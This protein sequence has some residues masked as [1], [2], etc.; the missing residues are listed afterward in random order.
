MK[1][2]KS[3]HVQWD[4]VGGGKEKFHFVPFQLFVGLAYH[5]KDMR[6]TKYPPIEHYT[7][8]VFLVF[9]HMYFGACMVLHKNHA[10]WFY[11]FFL[12]CKGT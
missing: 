11:M 5:G 8:P 4:L 1:D 10:A 6:V 12:F 2:A 9:L 3:R 7:T